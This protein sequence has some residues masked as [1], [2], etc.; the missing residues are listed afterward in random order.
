MLFEQDAAAIE[1]NRGVD[2]GL[3]TPANSSLGGAWL[4]SLTLCRQGHA[5][6]HGGGQVAGGRGQLIDGRAAASQETRLFQEVGGRVTAEDQ[7]GKDGE[8]RALGGRATAGRDNLIK[9]SG[10][11][12]DSWIDLGQR[13]LHSSSLIQC[14]DSQE[15]R[16]SVH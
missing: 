7:L 8:P 10:E 6:Q 2:G 9:I 1:Q 12:P 4:G 11:I 15:L 5:R 3:F 16:L 13:D 14:G